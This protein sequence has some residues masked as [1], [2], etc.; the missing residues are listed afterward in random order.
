MPVTVD[1]ALRDHYNEER[2]K[3]MET[4]VENPPRRVILKFTKAA[5]QDPYSRGQDRSKVSGRKWGR[6]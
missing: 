5:Y 6:T 3:I 2:F 4:Q 1:A